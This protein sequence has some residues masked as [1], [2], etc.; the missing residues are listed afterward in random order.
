MHRFLVKVKGHGFRHEYPA[1][2][3]SSFELWHAATVK[4]GLCQIRVIKEKSNV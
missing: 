4:Y 1:I 3:R 2:A